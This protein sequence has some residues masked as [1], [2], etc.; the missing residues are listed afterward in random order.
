MHNSR[1]TVLATISSLEAQTLKPDCVIVIDD[2][3]TDG[4]K[5]LLSLLT[6]SF[7]LIVVALPE[8]VGPAQARN[9]GVAHAKTT[10]V[11]FV[12]SD[13]IVLPGHFKVH[14]DLLSDNYPAITSTGYWFSDSGAVGRI[15]GR[16][17]RF[18]PQ[19][20]ILHHNFVCVASTLRRDIYLQLGGQRDE[21]MEDYDLWIRFFRSGYKMRTAQKPTFLYRIRSG[22]RSRSIQSLQLSRKVLEQAQTESSVAFERIWIRYGLKK[23]RDQQ[24]LNEID[25]A[26]GNR[27]RKKQILFLTLKLLVTAHVRLKMTALHRLACTLGKIK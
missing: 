22:S 15:K 24:L 8:N 6:F 1:E 9:V 27:N 7:E 23:I 18:A 13:D 19:I 12:D 20:K 17:P 5:E 10:Y 26:I 4:S 16:V 2:A 21:M 14:R 11:S 3:S 25:Q